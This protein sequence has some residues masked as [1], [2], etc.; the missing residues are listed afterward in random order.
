MKEFYVPEHDLSKRPRIFGMTA[1][2]ID[3]KSDPYE[4]A[5]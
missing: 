4:A 2:P 3:T 5:R 1:S